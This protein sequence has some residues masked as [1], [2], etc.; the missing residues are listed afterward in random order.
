MMLIAQSWMCEMFLIISIGAC[1]IWRSGSHNSIKCFEPTHTTLFPSKKRFPDLVY[2]TP[3]PSLYKLGWRKQLIN[4]IFC[5]VTSS[6]APD[7]NLWR[8]SDKVTE[9]GF[10]N[11]SHYDKPTD[12][13]HQLCVFEAVMCITESDVLI[14]VIKLFL[15]AAPWDCAAQEAIFFTLTHAVDCVGSMWGGCL[16]PWIRH[17]KRK[18]TDG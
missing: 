14:T 16:S 5:L 11:K 17:Y 4:Q 12:S 15:W 10:I 1:L 3:G 18:L 7:S 9:N 8:G 6:A 13:E 2:N